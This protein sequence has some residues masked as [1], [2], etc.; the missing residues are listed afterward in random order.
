MEARLD[1]DE[2]KRQANLL[3]HELDFA[4][5]GVVL[6][7]RYRL[8]VAVVRNGEVRVQSFSY[9]LNRLPPASE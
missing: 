6:E 8:D 7:S 3:K 1:W 2:P 5:A 9:V 4:D